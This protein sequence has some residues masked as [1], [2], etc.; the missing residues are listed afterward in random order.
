[1]MEAKKIRGFVRVSFLPKKRWWHRRKI[2]LLNDVL[3]LNFVI[4]AGFESDGASIPRFAAGLFPPFGRYLKAALLHDMAYRYPQEF[5]KKTNDGT[6]S[7]T[8][9]EADNLM[10]A[11]CTQLRIRWWRKWSIYIALRL[12]G[13]LGWR[14]NRRL[15][16]KQR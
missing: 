8:R 2:Q 7:I 12:F 5:M 16:R 3:V 13:W 6:R 1:M 4:K 14:Y 10:F 9:R 15:E 11:A